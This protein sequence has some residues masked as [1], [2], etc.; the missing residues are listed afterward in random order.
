M[1]R[2]RHLQVSRYLCLSEVTELCPVG[3]RY[4]MDGA[5]GGFGETQ[6]SILSSL[7]TTHDIVIRRNNNCL[8]PGL[9]WY[10]RSNE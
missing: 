8:S 9:K 1:Q 6:T 3:L 10:R 4:L 2:R 5:S 7:E